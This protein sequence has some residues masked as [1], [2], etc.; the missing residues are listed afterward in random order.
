MKRRTK[1][2]VSVGT[3]VALGLGGAGA[4]YAVQHQ[5]RAL[6]HTSIAGLDVGGR[7]R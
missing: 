1:V 7:V 5:D 6:P 3:A 4:A 2:L